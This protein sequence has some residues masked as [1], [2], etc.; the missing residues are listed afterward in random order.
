MHLPLLIGLLYK[1]EF[2]AYIDRFERVGLCLFYV[3]DVTLA[4]MMLSVIAVY[5]VEFLLI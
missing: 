5:L 4:G 1:L 3:S 2:I